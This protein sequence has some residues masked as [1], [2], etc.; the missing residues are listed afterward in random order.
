MKN[1][2]ASIVCCV[3][4][5][6]GLMA[7]STASPT[8]EQRVRAIEDKEAILKTMYAYAYLIDFG[9]EVHEYTDL[10]TEDAVFQNNLTASTTSAAPEDIRPDK[11]AVSGREGLEKW[12]I[13]EWQNRDRGRAAGRFSIHEFVEPDIVLAGDHATVRSYFQTTG[14]D[15]GRIY[16]VSIGQYKDTFERSADGHWRIK[17]RLLVRQG[18]TGN[19][20]GNANAPGA[21]PASPARGQ[22]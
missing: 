5:P 1:L 4:F 20:G 22:R 10:Y 19:N 15:N 8:L 18:P 11:G 6:L 12:I 9:K 7:Q 16:F 2:I 13:N 21:P 17:E 3:V 14:N